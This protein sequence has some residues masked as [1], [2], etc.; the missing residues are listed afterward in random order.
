MEKIICAYLSYMMDVCGTRHHDHYTRI[1]KYMVN[2]KGLYIKMEKTIFQFIP[3]ILIFLFLRYTENTVVVS[4]TVLGKLFAVSLILFYTKIDVMY[5]LIVCLL[6]IFYYQSDYVEGMKSSDE[7]KDKTDTK[8][9]TEHMTDEEDNT[10]DKTEHMTDEEHETN[11]K[12]K[13]KSEGFTEYAQMYQTPPSEFGQSVL[14]THDTQKREFIQQHCDHQTLKYKNQPVR[15]DA[16]EHIFNE[17]A[18]AETPCN[19]CSKGCPFV[20]KYLQQEE[21]LLRPNLDDK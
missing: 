10:K 21:A 11:T 8:D 19:V 2:I 17:I 9:K 13:D 1:V 18:F 7:T 16:T 15:P 12:S 5:G 6:V 14:D 20:F 3:I 4:H